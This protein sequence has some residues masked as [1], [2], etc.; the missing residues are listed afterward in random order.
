MEI[1]WDTTNIVM[2]PLDATKQID[3][4][5]MITNYVTDDARLEPEMIS[6]ATINISK[7][8]FPF[9]R[10]QRSVNMFGLVFGSK[11]LKEDGKTYKYNELPAMIQSED[12]KLNNYISHSQTYIGEDGRRI[13]EITYYKKTAFEASNIDTGGGGSTKNN[14]FC[15][16]FD[17]S[18]DPKE[19]FRECV[20]NRVGI[21]FPQ[22][23]ADCVYDYIQKHK[24]KAFTDTIVTKT[25][26][27]Q[28][29]DKVNFAISFEPCK[30][31]FGNT[32]GYKIKYNFRGL[33]GLIGDLLREGHYI[34][35]E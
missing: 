30:V 35:K 14:E 4:S 6:V 17:K 19:V 20:Y 33:V 21:P 24:Y 13:D 25:I 32:I 23:L 16:L 7:S 10:F 2:H 3:S 18:D 15:L 22:D 31:N 12:I 27:D 28:L 34:I 26:E 8:K 1:N 29:K 11:D 9:L 5:Y